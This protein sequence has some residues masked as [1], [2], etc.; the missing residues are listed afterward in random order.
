M[1]HAQGLLAGQAAVLPFAGE[2][3]ANSH[4]CNA[5]SNSIHDDIHQCQYH[6]S[7]LAAGMMDTRPEKLRPGLES[8]DIAAV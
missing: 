2:L 4:D 6:V 5:Q 1:F 7:R 3:P 8:L